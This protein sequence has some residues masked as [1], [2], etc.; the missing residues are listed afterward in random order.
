MDQS[1]ANEPTTSDLLRAVTNLNSGIDKSEQAQKRF[2]VLS[3]ELMECNDTGPGA[4]AQIKYYKEF[5]KPLIV[6]FSGADA[7]TAS[8]GSGS[9]WMLYLTDVGASH[10]TLGLN[11]RLRYYG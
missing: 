4:Y 10:P 11:V 9:L 3:D 2:I 1:G 6:R 7:T 5:K 8:A